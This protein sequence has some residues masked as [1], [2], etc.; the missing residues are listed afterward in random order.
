MLGDRMPRHLL[1]AAKPYDSAHRLLRWHCNS[2]SVKIETSAGYT[3]TEG[4]VLDTQPD[5]QSSYRI[6]LCE[7]GVQGNTDV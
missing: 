3:N 5:S 4:E 6:A 7:N 2:E 1:S